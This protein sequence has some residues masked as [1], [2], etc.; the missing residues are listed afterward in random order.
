[1]KNKY[2][3]WQ[4]KRTKRHRQLA[5]FGNLLVSISKERNQRLSKK[6]FCPI[7]GRDFQMDEK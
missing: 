2:S 3:E 1:M 4:E 5:C 6:S 7:C